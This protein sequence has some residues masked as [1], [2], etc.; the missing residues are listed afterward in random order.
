MPPFVPRK[1]VSSED[2][3]SAKRQNAALAVGKIVVEDSESDASLS[4]APSSDNGDTGDKNVTQES[5]KGSDDA[6]G[7][8]DEVDW[9]DAMEDTTANTVNALNNLPSVESQDLE[10]TLDKNEVHMADLLGGKKGPTKIERQIR[11]RTHCLH[12]QMLLAH[13]AVRNAWVNDSKVHGILQ[14]KLPPGNP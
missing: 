5:N 12:V 11:I 3:P 9:E 6:D 10:L 7:D 2:P 1:R 13:N 14:R 4:D 8:D